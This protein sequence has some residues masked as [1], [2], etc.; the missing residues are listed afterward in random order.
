M[1]KH[2]FPFTHISPFITLR[3]IGPHAYSFHAWFE[4]N[5]IYATHFHM[6]ISSACEIELENFMISV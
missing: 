3:C 1:K 5:I 6:R 2:N 4:G